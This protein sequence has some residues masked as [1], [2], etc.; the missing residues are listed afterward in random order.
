MG[1]ARTP[2]AVAARE[3]LRDTLFDAARDAMQERPW[4]EVT[5]AEIASAA[6]VSRQTLYKEFG[7]RDEFAQL[8]VVREGTRF[9][10]AVEQAVRAH[11]DD[12]RAALAGALGVF[13]R[14]ASEDPLVRVLLTDDGTG[15]MLP[16]VT[17]QSRPVVAFASARLTE[18]IHDGWPQVAYADAE[19]LAE[20][21]VRLAISYAMLPKDPPDAAITTVMTV[22]EPFVEQ[23]LGRG[24]A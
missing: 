18:V 19:L 23:A 15:G 16:L 5:M 24:P 4:A 7:S 21:L 9:L 11:L 14:A 13:L 20:T 1:P 12:P 8:F 22:I 17:T 2:Y 6:G 10:D 3:L